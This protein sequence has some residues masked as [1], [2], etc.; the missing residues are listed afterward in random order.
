[1][2][3]SGYEAGRNRQRPHSLATVT[4]SRTDKQLLRTPVL[5]PYMS[6]IPSFLLKGPFHEHL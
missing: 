6:K 5:T 1:M 4:P 2:G 3:D